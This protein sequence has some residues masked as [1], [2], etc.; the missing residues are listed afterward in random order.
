MNFPTSHQT[1]ADKF[2]SSYLTRS[3]QL[4][5]QLKDQSPTQ[6]CAPICT[7]FRSVCAQ[8][9]HEHSWPALRRVVMCKATCSTCAATVSD[10]GPTDAEITPC[11]AESLLE[12]RKTRG[13]GNGYIRVTILNGSPQDPGISWRGHL[14]TV[15]Y[16]GSCQFAATTATNSSFVLGLKRLSFRGL[17]RRLHVSKLGKKSERTVTIR[18]AWVPARRKAER[19]ASQWRVQESL[20][21]R[22]KIDRLPS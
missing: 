22:Y 15:A 11:C 1:A 2:V 8:D 21:S 13:I 19:A 3:V 10:C 18:P 4:R 17:P 20:P 9:G 7:H 5:S 14:V 16:S 12:T 6:T